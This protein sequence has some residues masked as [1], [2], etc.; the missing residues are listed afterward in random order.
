MEL[1]FIRNTVLLLLAVYVQ[2]SF[3]VVYSC[4]TTAACGCSLNTAS[5]TRI[6]GGELA[7]TSTWGWAVSIRLGSGGLCGGAIISSQWILTAA[8]CVT[9]Y[10]A[11]QVTVYAG[12]NTMWSG[13]SRSVSSITRHPSYSSSTNRNDI[14]LLQLSSALNM[15][16]PNVKI[17]CIPSVSSSVL[18][19][20]EWPPAN[21]DV[22]AVGWGT[23]SSGGSTS[24]SLRQVTMSTIG[25][26][27]S[28][29]SSVLNDVT[30]QFCAGIQC[31]GRD[32][33]QGD[34]GGPIM[35]FTTSN[36]WVI[37]GVTSYGIG[38]AS[39]SYAGVYTRIA[40]Y[41]TWIATTM[42]SSPLNPASSGYTLSTLISRCN[43][44]TTSVVTTIRST[45]S[46]NVSSRFTSSWTSRSLILM[47]ITLR[48]V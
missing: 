46:S 29:C 6:V 34:S 26:T 7:G 9:S 30:L 28:M 48:W 40:A 19:A 32:T 18:S 43:T 3:Q 24:S 20:G 4:N 45:T 14:A 27:V 23:T 10:S 12:S 21:V 22:V 39:A 1:T 41:Q 15:A 25:A 5:V 8:H 13:Q 36:Q 31:G 35:I 38:C 42:G 47:L 33:C 37:V 2:R 17:A 16:D 44:S 11:S